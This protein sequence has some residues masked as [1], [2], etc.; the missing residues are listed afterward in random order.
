M[1]HSIL[2][3]YSQFMKIAKNS[4]IS[5]ESNNCNIKRRRKTDIHRKKRGSINIMVTFPKIDC[6]Q[7]NG[8]DEAQRC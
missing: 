8:F 1:L 7:L 2:P 5:T 4:S 6:D 3:V